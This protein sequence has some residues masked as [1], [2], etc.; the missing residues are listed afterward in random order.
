MNERFTLVWH[1]SVKPYSLTKGT[2]QAMK[3]WI[4]RG[5]QLQAGI[6]QPKF[7][8]RPV[9]DYENES[10]RLGLSKPSLESVELLDISRVLEVNRID[11]KLYPL[12]KRNNCFLLETLDRKIMFEASCESERDRIVHNMKLMVARFGS[13]VIVRDQDVLDE[14]FASFEK[15]APGEAPRWTQQSTTLSLL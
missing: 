4:E 5:Q 6:I 7:V 9:Q 1:R 3:A 8:W 15:A 10:Q 12:A 2:P 13:K 14:F 11:R